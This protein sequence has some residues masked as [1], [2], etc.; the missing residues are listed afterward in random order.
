M[1]SRYSSSAT[2]KSALKS[3]LRNSS[4]LKRKD[5]VQAMLKSKLP[6]NYRTPFR[7]DNPDLN[8]LDQ[9]DGSSY[10]LA[11]YQDHSQDWSGLDSR[12]QYSSEQFYNQSIRPY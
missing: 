4:N 11:M 7:Y 3:P 10:Q 2:R 6:A 12:A 8:E 1:R 5:D 9:I